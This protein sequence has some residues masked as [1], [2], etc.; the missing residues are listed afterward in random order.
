MAEGA[1]RI[2]VVIGVLLITGVVSQAA[3]LKKAMSETE[4]RKRAAEN[5]LKEIKAKA[6]PSEQVRRAYIE[7]TSQQNAWLD[8]VCNAI[9]QGAASEPDVS[10]AA[11]AAANSLIAWVNVRNV[12]L[13]LP[14]VTGAL[15]DSVKKTITLH[16][17]DI[18]SETWKNNR[19]TDAKK[20]TT[21]ANELKE[22]LRWKAFEEI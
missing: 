17:T 22:R 7:A 21:A 12:A 11:Q 18:A 13:S 10:A 3:D 14:E 9:E 8:S 19:S 5:G 16:L 6:Q 15:A 1:R 20:R 4:S 2:V